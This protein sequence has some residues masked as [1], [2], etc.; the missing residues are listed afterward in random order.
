MPDAGHEL[1][2]ASTGD[3]MEREEAQLRAL[4]VTGRHPTAGALRRL[5]AAQAAGTPV[6]EITDHAPRRRSAKGFAQIGF[7]HDAVGCAMTRHLLD[8]GHTPLAHVD[9]GIAE[10]SAPTNAAKASRTRPAPPAPGW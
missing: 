6:I 2:L 9:S 7:D 10:D 5:E 4:I 8:Q 1:P 3:S